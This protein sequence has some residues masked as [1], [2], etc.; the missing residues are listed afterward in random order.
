MNRTALSLAIIGLAFVAGPAVQAQQ[1][2]RPNV[3]RV[4]QSAQKADLTR[5]VPSIEIIHGKFGDA[6]DALRDATGASI[7]VNWKSLEEFHIDRSDDVT[8]SARNVS[9][10]DALRMLLLNAS[11]GR[12]EMGIYIDQNVICVDTAEECKWSRKNTRV[13]DIRDLLRNV[14]GQ[15]R[16]QQVTR[17]IKLLTD[18]IDPNSWTDLSSRRHGSIKELQGQ[19]IVT[20]TPEN[21][22]AIVEMIEHLRALFGQKLESAPKLSS[23]TR[24]S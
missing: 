15:E 23:T 6:F 7:F 16:G 9:L 19:L 11:H 2:N 10:G 14:A 22:Q 12:G 18:C 8:F 4:T 13:Y 3:Q 21:Q 20:Q 5:I 1:S 24:P 17:I